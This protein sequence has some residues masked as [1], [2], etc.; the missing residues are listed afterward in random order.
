MPKRIDVS[1]L[2]GVDFSALA[3]KAK[4]ARLRIRLLGLMQLQKGKTINAVAEIFG[5]RWKTV[6]SWLIKF[7]A[8]GTEGLLDKPRSGRKPHLEAKHIE[9]F[10]KSIEALQI[11]RLG[12]R[13]TAKDIQKLLSKKFKAEYDLDSIYKVLKK[14]KIVWIT[15]R[16]VHP[17]ADIKAQETFKKTL[18]KK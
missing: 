12:G 15:A 4:T 1:K 8:S 13:I 2:Q 6:K 18:L 16:S 14:V 7:L 3:K 9:A 11:K 10:K 5:V 17:K